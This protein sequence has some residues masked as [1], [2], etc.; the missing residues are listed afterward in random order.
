MN[1]PPQEMAVLLSAMADMKEQWIRAAS[2]GK[3]PRPE[4]VITLAKRDLSVL[5]QAA[6]A[7]RAKA[8][9]A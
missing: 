6:D 3:D 2:G 7:Y 4:H 1:R 8:E 5:R 9:R